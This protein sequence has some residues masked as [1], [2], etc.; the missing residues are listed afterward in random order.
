MSDKKYLCFK[1]HYGFAVYLPDDGSIS[2]TQVV[3][4]ATEATKDD[5]SDVIGMNLADY[6]FVPA[7]IT[8]HQ[9]E[10]ELNEAITLKNDAIRHLQP[11]LD[12]NDKLQ[13]LLEKCERELNEA[14]RKCICVFCKTEFTKDAP[15][16]PDHILTC[17]KSPLVQL[18]KDAKE[19]NDRICDEN[20][21]LEK[22]TEKARQEYLN[23]C[24]NH[25]VSRQDRDQWKSLAQ[26]VISKFKHTH[27]N[28]GIDD[29]CKQ[30]GFDLRH[31]IHKR[32]D[33]N[34]QETPCPSPNTNNE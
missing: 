6:Q 16:L 31:E 21:Q 26:E 30:C 7:E 32:V 3:G 29:S 22:A 11:V 1:P 24:C 27:V 15:E 4:E 5:W 13:D 33:S 17:E 23:E 2:H 10:R 25:E 9:L 20:E 12:N 18:V 28:N 8:V 34:T 14:A 19:L